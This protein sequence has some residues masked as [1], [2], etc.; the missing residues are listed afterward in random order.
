MY[1]VCS[2]RG[3]VVTGV[4][5]PRSV[6]V[7]AQLV[8]CCALRTLLLEPKYAWASHSLTAATGRRKRV[9]QIY[10]SDELWI[11]SVCET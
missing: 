4:R 2:C 6:D 8:G 11:L 9:V 1:E 10:M 7:V 3:N 5:T